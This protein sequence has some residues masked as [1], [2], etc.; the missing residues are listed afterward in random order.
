MP[1]NTPVNSI[2]H[3]LGYTF[4]NPDLLELALTHSS[5]HGGRRPFELV[6]YE[7]LEFLGDRVLGLLVADL[8]MEAFPNEEEGSL[9]KRH[10]ALVR[11]ETLAQVALSVGVDTH[12]KLGI[13]DENLR[14]N[15]TVLADVCEAIIGALYQDGGLN[16]ARNFVTQNWNM[17]L[18]SAITPPKDSKTELQEWVQKKGHPLPI[19]REISRS[20]PDHNPEFVIEVTVQGQSSC[21]ALGKSKREGQQNAAQLMM[22]QIQK[23]PKM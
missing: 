1:M 11:R 7:R 2:C 20:G 12:M 14:T 17:M 18:R 23:Q 15:Q 3:N 5:V 22:E 21:C 19:Y 13:F 10:A 4:T 8:L 9:A 6:D 16:V